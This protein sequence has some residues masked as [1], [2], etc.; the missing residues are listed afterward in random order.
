MHLLQRS[1]WHNNDNKTVEVEESG[2][3]LLC[4]G[5][6]NTVRRM[7]GLV[8]SGVAVGAILRQPRE[9]GQVKGLARWSRG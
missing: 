3:I 8:P 7:V 4:T 1:E 6:L 9:R 5:G 2:R